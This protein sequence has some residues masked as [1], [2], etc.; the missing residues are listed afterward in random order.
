MNHTIL[1]GRPVADPETGHQRKRQAPT[2]GSGSRT[3]AATAPRAP[4]ARRCS[5]TAWP[6]TASPRASSAATSAR[7]RSSPSPG[8]W[9]PT[10]TTAQDTKYR[11]FTLVVDDVVLPDRP[12]SDS[13]QQEAE[14]S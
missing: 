1:S 11:S 9:S 10:T 8:G 6:S 3:I 7:A 12:R 14:P 5:S 2:R 4:S 13:D